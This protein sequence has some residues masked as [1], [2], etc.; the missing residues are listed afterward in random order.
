MPPTL[1]AVAAL[2]QLGLRPLTGGP[3]ALEA[4]V[5]WVAVSELEDPTPFLEGGELLLTTGMRLNA[6]TAEPYIARLVRRRVAGLGFGVGLGHEEIPPEL[7]GA[8]ERHGLPLLE[9]PRRT[10]F[11]AIGKA[12][13]GMLAAERYEAVT[14]SFQAQRE[15]TRA[16]LKG[17]KALVIR[18]AR[19]LD[20]WALLLG[21]TGDVLRAAPESARRHADDLAGELDRLRAGGASVAISGRDS[22]VVIQ[23][24]GVSGRPRGFLA[25]GTAEPLP[26]VAHT[27]VGAAVSLLTLR[28]E[29]P[30]ADRALRAALASLLL[31]EP[32]TTPPN[33]RAAA[34]APSGVPAVG[35]LDGVIAPPVRVL[36]CGAGRAVL[37]ALEAAPGGDRCLAVELADGRAVIVPETAAEPVI[38]AVAATG[39]VG[40]SDATGLN[41]LP[42]A[43]IQA[44]RARA[45]AGRNGPDVLRYAE[46]PGRGVHGLLD[47]EAARGFAD[48]L[49]SPLRDEDPEL[50]RSLH[51]YLAANGQGETAAR[52]LGVHRHTL[53]HRMRKAA[54]ILGRD[55]DDP[56]VRAELWIAL[57]APAR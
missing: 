52:A 39:P 17:S 15:L 56:G 38:A 18:L 7:T 47:P 32:P 49:L 28:S 55:L 36:F 9:V 27:I 1:A 34:P 40:V 3:P 14:R 2:P 35:G 46:L 33:D 12:V 31:G 26:P 16:A 4:G 51:A 43:L 6:R 5:H 8:A 50:V 44:R 22:H 20:G 24:L 48:G 41:G 19:E 11:I 42:T 37:E 30:S 13:S 53:R 10:P 29:T 57:T 25:V 45:A 54:E 21:P 23:P